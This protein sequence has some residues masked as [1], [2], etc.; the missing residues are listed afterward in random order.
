M[1]GPTQQRNKLEWRRPLERAKPTEQD[2]A[3]GL[4]RVSHL[5][6]PDAGATSMGEASTRGSHNEQ[7]GACGLSRVGYSVSPAAGATPLGEVSS[8]GNLLEREPTTRAE[9]LSRPDA[10]LWQKA[11]DEEY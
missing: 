6:S 3:R 7:S 2:G 4:S 8:G 11:M 10:G 1:G 9:A 5:V